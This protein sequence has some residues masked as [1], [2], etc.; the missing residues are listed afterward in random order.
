MVQTPYAIPS[1]GEITAWSERLHVNCVRP[2]CMPNQNKESIEGPSGAALSDIVSTFSS[3]RQCFETL[4]E[5]K[6]AEKEEKKDKWSKTLENHRNMILA[7]MTRDGTS[8]ALSPTKDLRRVM[9]SATLAEAQAVVTSVLKREGIRMKLPLIFVKSLMS[10]DWHNGDV[11]SPSKLSF[12]FLNPSATIDEDENLRLHLR[13]TEGKGLSDESISALMKKDLFIPKSN[14]ELR[15]V[16]R[17]GTIV[18]KCFFGDGIITKELKSCVETLIKRDM[19]VKRHF[20]NDP[21]FGARFIAAIDNHLNNLLDE[22]EN[23]DQPSEINMEYFSMSHIFHQVERGSFQFTLPS[24][25]QSKRS[26]EALETSGGGPRSKKP[27]S[28]EVGDDGP[29][30]LVRNECMIVGEWKPNQ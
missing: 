8:A 6:R 3:T 1:N 26:F 22:C 20:R 13:S 12:F 14:Y 10:G 21:L 19:A 11:D 25:L 7:F 30:K 24:I 29:S 9:D 16:I 18:S 5:T 23:A 4:L 15:E 27:K 17:M 28:P 2:T